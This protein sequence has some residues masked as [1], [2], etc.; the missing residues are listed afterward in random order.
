MKG[1]LNNDVCFS[2]LKGTI[3]GAFNTDGADR[4]HIDIEEARKAFDFDIV[5]M[6]SFTEDG[7]PIDR[8]FH[9]RRSD[10]DKIIPTR[11]V[12]SEFAPLQHMDVYDFIVN[13]IMPKVPSMTLETVGTMHGGAT[14][15]VMAKLGDDFSISGDRSP[16]SQRLFFFNPNG[17]S[18]VV[19]GMTTVRLWCQNQIPAAVRTASANGFRLWHT[20]NVVHNTDLALHT[21][22]DQVEAVRALR[23][24]E[25]RLAQ[26]PATDRELQYVLDAVVPLGGY[27]P[28]TRAWTR[29]INV[30]DE[31]VR[32]FNDGET[33]Q[34]MDGRK[35]GWTLLNAVT[36]PIFNPATMRKDTDIAQITYSGT[37]G[38]RS[39]KAAKILRTVE[40]VLGA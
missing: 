31:I 6:Q 10:D 28:E 22:A 12:G 5:K 2:T 25:E 7:R 24:R 11:S 39:L 30:R 18:S 3:G 33:A 40:N 19:I 17:Q 8:H 35:N 15:V 34:E 37:D 27:I 14:G 29:A 16:Q 23:Q 38:S 36:R 9:L 32:Q 13:D 21:I 26:I 1:I 4:D 20:R